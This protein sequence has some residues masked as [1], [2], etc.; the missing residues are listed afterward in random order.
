MDINHKLYKLIENEQ[1]VEAKM[2]INKI[3]VSSSKNSSFISLLIKFYIKT[4]DNDNLDMLYLNHI[5][6]L[7]KRDIL[8]YSNHYYTNEYSSKS[9]ESFMYLIN[10]YNLGS[11]DLKYLIE[12]RMYKFIKLLDGYYIKLN[13]Y[14][15]YGQPIYNY[16]VLKKYQFNQSVIHKILS[17]IHLKNRDT[18]LIFCNYIENIKQ[19][20]VIIDAGNILHSHGGLV[21]IKG[22]KFLLKQV[23]YYI[24]NDIVPVIVIHT[25]HLKTKFKGSLKNKDIIECINILKTEFIHLIYE[26]PYHMNDDF[27]IIYLALMIQCKILSN[28]NYKDHICNF[29]EN[30]VSGKNM[31][32][33]Y[34]DDLVINY[35]RNIVMDYMNFSKCIQVIDRII[36]IPTID[37]FIVK[38]L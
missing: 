32:H 7:R 10:N 22:Y 21:T 34:I 19:E 5:E 6:N 12:N 30:D 36:Y 28:D 9:L 11:S 31:T 29:R 8:A 18:F 38:L 35:S 20:K 17:Q 37:N 14:K 33:H 4:S 1:L 26:T 27:Y 2:L 24:S 15:N 25:R 13:N 23:K 3:N 16:S